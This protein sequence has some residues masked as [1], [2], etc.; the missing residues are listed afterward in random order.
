[1]RKLALAVLLSLFAADARAGAPPKAAQPAANQLLYTTYFYTAAEAVVHGYEKDT[2]VRIVSLEHNATVWT[3]KI[4]PGETALVRTGQGVFG[5]LADKKASIL[6][7][8]PSSCTAVGYFVK[9]RDGSFRSDQFYAQLPSSVSAQGAKVLMF[10]WDDVSYDISDVA[11]KHSIHKGQLKAGRY[12]EMTAQELSGLS[13]HVLEFKA[14][15][16][17]IEVEVYYD[18]GFI[19]PSEDGRGAGRKFMTY[20][21][22][23]TN[24]ENDLLL[25]AYNAN[26]KATVEDLENGKTIWSG[27]V[28]KG[29]LIPI[30]MINRHVKVTSDVEIAVMVAAYKHY[31]GIYAEHHFS[32][33]AEGTGI[34][35]DFLTNTSQELWIF[36]Y[37]KG[38]D[39]EVTNAETGAPVW[40]GTL[41]AGQVKGLTPGFGYYR[42]RS[43][44]GVSVM[45]GAS[46]CG[47]EYSPAAGMFAVDE[48]LFKVMKQIQ[49]ERMQQAQQQHRSISDAELKA[50]LSRDEMKRAEKAL[51]ES[52]RAASGKG[53]P[54]AA[55][56]APTMTPAEVQ[57][58]MDTLM[59]H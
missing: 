54:A 40:K 56:P 8:T 44:R 37:F 51:A 30:T 43:S 14:D 59:A 5:F 21:G 10:A 26:A 57:Q 24:G 20:L 50:P 4:G 12:F 32:M 34:D 35:H 15:K 38:A 3:G 11:T 42:V 46:A 27:A 16:P 47:G 31:K 13:S 58:R 2:N 18:E 28:P 22:D 39:V 41:H 49:T 45:G 52:P 6:V 1:M 53:A 7:G 17:A 55:A 25:M 19:V 9:N 36:S 29:G 48:T 23:I 33:G